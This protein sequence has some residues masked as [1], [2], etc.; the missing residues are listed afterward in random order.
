MVAAA[1]STAAEVTAIRR[2]LHP[3]YSFLALRLLPSRL[4]RLPRSLTPTMSQS[5]TQHYLEPHEAEQAHA[6]RHKP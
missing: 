1:A 4:R 3:L 5:S 2:L 6:G